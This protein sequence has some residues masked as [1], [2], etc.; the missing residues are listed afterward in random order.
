MAITNLE[1]CSPRVKAWFKPN[2][3]ENLYDML[4]LKICRQ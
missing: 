4:I 1:E 3:Q 2:D